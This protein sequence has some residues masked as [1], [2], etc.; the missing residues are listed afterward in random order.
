MGVLSVQ[1]PLKH[2]HLH[3]ERMAHVKISSLFL[4]VFVT[5][6]LSDNSWTQPQLQVQNSGYTEPQQSNNNQGFQEQFY[7]QE[8][9]QQIVNELQQ[10]A[11]YAYQG[12]Q[13]PVQQVY[14]NS[15]NSSNNNSIN[16]YINNKFQSIKIR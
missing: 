5:S 8:P 7:A 4:I 12:G 14:D 13:Q 2:T 1:P 3:R 15:V 11:E 9:Q 6:A 10:N 16:R